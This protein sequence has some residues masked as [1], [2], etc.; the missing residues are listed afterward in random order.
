METTLEAVLPYGESDKVFDPRSFARE[1][2]NLYAA[3]D[4]SL[5]AVPGY[6]PYVPNYGAGYPSYGRW[7]GVFHTVVENSTRD[8]LIIRCGDELRAQSGWTN[9]WETLTTGLSNDP[10][11]QFPD[12]FLE[13]N[14]RVV[15]S[16]G[17]DSARIYDGYRLLPLG[18]DRAPGAPTALGPH[19]DD[20]GVYKNYAGYSHPG[21]IGTVGDVLNGTEGALLAGR[22]RYAVQFVDA[23]GC[24]SPLSPASNEVTLRTEHTAV[25]AGTAK[26]LL[27]K[28]TG[29]DLEWMAVTLDDLTRQFA[30]KNIDR[31]PSGTVARRLFRTKDLNRNPDTYHFLA[32][33][34]DNTVDLYP[35]NIPDGWLGS[36]ATEYRDVPTFKVACVHQGRLVVGNT[37]ALANVVY[38][39]EPGSASFPSSMWALAGDGPQVTGLVS[40]NSKCLCFT[41]TS[42]YI[43]DMNQNG[44]VPYQFSASIGCVAPGS[45]CATGWGSLVWLGQDGL[46]ELK[47]ETIQKVS[48]DKDVSVVRLLTAYPGRAQ[49]VWDYDAKEYVLFMPKAGGNGSIF[50]IAYD[51]KNF[52]R[53]DYSLTTRAV[54][55]TRDRRRLLLAGGTANGE[56]SSNL[57]VLNR[58]AESYSP[59]SR[60]FTF[61]SQ[62]LG[63]DPMRRKFFNVNTVYLGF[64]EYEAGSAT[65]EL[66]SNGRIKN[67]PDWQKTFT[68]Q[69]DDYSFTPTPLAGKLN[70]AVIDTT[71]FA[72][73]RVFW[74]RFD[75]NLRSVSHFSFELT[76]TSRFALIG[77]ACDLVP[78][79]RG[80]RTSRM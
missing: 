48:M 71:R 46:Y 36:P 55:V 60:S 9:G 58:E 61:K 42:A 14:G 44:V 16:N 59:P 21:K 79:D 12:V 23:N 72:G 75:C 22:W 13:F 70:A 80:A 77:F 10:N 41:E 20:D 49:A 35:D 53:R 2:T 8:I 47:G 25:A 43:L 33:I 50:A 45:L 39:S 26:K 63:I 78:L 4:G 11:Q 7:H 32:N 17:I 18:Y 54:C 28:D 29:N 40:Y 34:P 74:L 37:S 56:G 57:F 64:V 5:R 15:W 69:P 27:W 6:C 52:R 65:L 51:G 62:W 67:S 68:M 73:A 3:P 24:V 76:S 19:G 30:V 38:V 31:G 1:I 66:H